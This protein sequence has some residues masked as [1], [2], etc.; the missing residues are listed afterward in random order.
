MTLLLDEDHRNDVSDLLF[1]N[2]NLWDLELEQS[3]QKSIEWLKAFWWFLSNSKKA[4]LLVIAEYN[5]YRVSFHDLPTLN[6]LYMPCSFY[7]HTNSRLHMI[8]G[9]QFYIK[10]LL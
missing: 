9:I 10:L 7:N 3:L 2:L 5:K 6:H 1:L 4:G 8:S